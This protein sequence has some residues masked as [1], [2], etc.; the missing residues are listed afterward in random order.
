MAGVEVAGIADDHLVDHCWSIGMGSDVVEPRI[1]EAMVL[2]FAD[3]SGCYSLL[4]H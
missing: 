3:D 2:G 1:E 4:D